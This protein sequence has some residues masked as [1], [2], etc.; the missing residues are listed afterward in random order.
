[1]AIIG[2]D[3]EAST[4]VLTKGRDFRWNFVNLD[5]SGVAVNFPAGTLY[6]ELATTTPQTWLF[7][8]SGSGASLKVESIV[9]DTVPA[10]TKWQLV[11]KATGEVAGGDPI[12]RGSVKVQ[13]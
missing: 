13:E 8:I 3:I 2:V 7:T 10:R 6:F 12:A 1:M 4:L 9:V 11:F 5:E